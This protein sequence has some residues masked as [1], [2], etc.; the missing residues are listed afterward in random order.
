MLFSAKD[1]R[2]VTSHVKNVA[3]YNKTNCL[4]TKLVA[5]RMTGMSCQQTLLDCLVTR[6]QTLNCVTCHQK[7][8]N[9][10]FQGTKKDTQVTRKVQNPTSWV[11]GLNQSF[12]SR[13]FQVVDLPKFEIV[14]VNSIT[15]GD[16]KND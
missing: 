12:T 10:N 16:D 2:F 5:H 6:N 11:S 1:T 3:V 15:N 9:C 8:S 7:T 13:P 14:D 4:L